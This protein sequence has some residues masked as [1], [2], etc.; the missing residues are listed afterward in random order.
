MTSNG[1]NIE[2]F[3]IMDMFCKNFAS[4]YEKRLHL[5]DKDYCHQN[6]KGGCCAYND[7][8]LIAL[9]LKLLKIK[10]ICNYLYIIILLY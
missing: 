5:E 7:F 6:R 8:C 9:I 3:C 10:D 1:K 4:E 2:I